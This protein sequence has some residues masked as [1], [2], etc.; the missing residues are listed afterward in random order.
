MKKSI[1]IILTILVL[2]CGCSFANVHHVGTNGQFHSILEAVNNSVNGDTILVA[3]GIYKEKNIVINKSIVLIGDR[4]PVLDG[5]RQFE[6][7]SVKADNVTIK[8]FKLI[9]SGISSL[10]YCRYKSIYKKRSYH[11]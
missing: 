3:Q 4:Y 8:G 1:T 5:E 6:I 7:I 10:G 9:H 11:F 2:G